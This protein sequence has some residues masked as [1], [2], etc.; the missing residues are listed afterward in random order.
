MNRSSCSEKTLP[1][2]IFTKG[3]SS[4]SSSTSRF[5]RS[6]TPSRRSRTNGR[7]TL[8]T[9]QSPRL[10]VFSDNDANPQGVV[11][12]RANVLSTATNPSWRDSPY[13]ANNEFLLQPVHTFLPV[14]P[15][16][17]K[18][19]TFRKSG[20]NGAHSQGS[21]QN[22]GSSSSWTKYHAVQRLYWG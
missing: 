17:T 7:Y 16:L 13:T 1:C 15:F 3:F 21:G 9:K 18:S 8:A 22:I 19:S 6:S 2:H 10:G 5:L 14:L 11:H 4:L 20:S 12:P